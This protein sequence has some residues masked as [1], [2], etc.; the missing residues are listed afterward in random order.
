VRDA[1][2]SVLTVA[3]LGWVGTNLAFS[4]RRAFRRRSHTVDLLRGVRL[5]HVWPAPFVL[6]A[7]LAVFAVLWLLPPLRVGWWSLLGGE[8]NVVFGTTEQTRGTAW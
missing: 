4:A 3:V 6:V 7:V 5:R 2:I 1:F 8:G